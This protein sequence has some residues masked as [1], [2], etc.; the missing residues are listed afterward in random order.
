MEV[1][2]TAAASSSS[3]GS[4]GQTTVNYTSTTNFDKTVA[5]TLANVTVGSC[6]SAFNT[7]GFGAAGSSTTTTTR[8][9]DAD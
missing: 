9:V 5:A 1:Q 6:V 2:S 8:A 4:G 7:S 3:G